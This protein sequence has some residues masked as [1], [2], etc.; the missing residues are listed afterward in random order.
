[1]F[2]LNKNYILKIVKLGLNIGY[3]IREESAPFHGFMTGFC[4]KN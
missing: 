2:G 1:M 4:E 3:E